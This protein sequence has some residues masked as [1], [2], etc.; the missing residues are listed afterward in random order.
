MT[1]LNPNRSRDGK[2]AEKIQ[3]EASLTLGTPGTGSSLGAA[4]KE[5]FESAKELHEAHAQNDW[6]EAVRA[7]HPDAAYA[8]P[9]PRTGRGNTDIRRIALHDVDGTDITLT[10]A[11]S[12]AFTDGYNKSWDMGRHV[13]AETNKIFVPD[14]GVFSL[15]SVEN[16]WNDLAGRATAS[17]DS[18]P[19]AH[20]TGME[21]ATAQ[22]E[23][24]QSLNHEATAAYVDDISAKILA[25]NPDAARLYVNRKTD[26]EYGLTFSLD[27]VEDADRNAVDVDLSALE[28]DA[29]Q[30]LHLDT[31]VQYDDATEELY[32]NIDPGH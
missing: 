27:R 3:S 13:T 29:F 20:L 8:Y 25:V 18:D 31:H 2:Y 24:A 4:L 7:K 9:V 15:D 19:F 10:P 5:R 26:V 16:R 32:I 30:D 21:K 23:Y 14:I 12:D 17:L 6:V 28:Q 11:D 1:D 22:S